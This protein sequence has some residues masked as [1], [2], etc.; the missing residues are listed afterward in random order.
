MHGIRVSFVSKKVVKQCLMIL[1]VL[2][3]LKIGS[4]I[5]SVAKKNSWLTLNSLYRDLW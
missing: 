3:C 1:I 5:F 4:E 2:I